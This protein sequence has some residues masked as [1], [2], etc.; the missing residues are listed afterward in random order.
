MFQAEINTKKQEEDENPFSVDEIES[1][2]FLGN[3]T[4]ASNFNFLKSKNISHILT[5]E[6]FPLPSY[7]SSNNNGKSLK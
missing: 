6:S 5:I 7:V 4:A 3:V 2:L 1:R